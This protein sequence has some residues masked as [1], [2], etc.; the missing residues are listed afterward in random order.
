MDYQPMDGNR[1]VCT[2]FSI[3]DTLGGRRGR[4]IEYKEMSTADDKGMHWSH[5]GQISRLKLLDYVQYILT[6]LNVQVT[7]ASNS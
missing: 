4:H 3:V 6:K 7:C 5:T 2:I 1:T